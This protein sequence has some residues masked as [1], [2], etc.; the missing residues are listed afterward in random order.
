MIQVKE[1]AFTLSFIRI[2]PFPVV[3]VPSKYTCGIKNS[4]IIGQL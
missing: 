3:F 2:Q 1:T 4:G